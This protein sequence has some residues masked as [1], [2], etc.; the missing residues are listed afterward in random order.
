MNKF[1][2]ALAAALG[3]GVGAAGSLLAAGEAGD[4][5]YRDDVH[6]DLTSKAAD[7]VVECIK[8]A[9][10]GVDIVETFDCAI[11]D[12]PRCRVGGLIKRTDANKAKAQGKVTYEVPKSVDVADLDA[13]KAE[14]IK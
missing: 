13:V 1:A 9:V 2:V 7:D 12:K 14:I 3:L 5:F 10:P 8:A 11:D 6:A 4:M